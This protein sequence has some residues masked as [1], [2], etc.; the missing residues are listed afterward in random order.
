MRANRRK[1]GTA[2]ISASASNANANANGSGTSGA[3][4]RTPKYRNSKVSFIDA[5]RFST[6]LTSSSHQSI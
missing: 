2:A 3:S 5:Q 1:S 4:G 6:T